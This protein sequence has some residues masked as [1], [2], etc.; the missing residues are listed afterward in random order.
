MKMKKRIGAGV[1]AIALALSLAACGEGTGNS[2]SEVMSQVG[3]QGTANMTPKAILTQSGKASEDLTDIQA[4]M[5]AEVKMTAQGETMNMDIDM[6]MIAK[7]SPVRAQM[8]M[9]INLSL[10]GEKQSQAMNMYMLE[11]NGKVSMYLGMDGK[12]QKASIDLG[13]SQEQLEKYSKQVDTSV[14]TQDM[15]EEN[16]KVS[17]YLGMDGKWQKASI[18][19]G[20]SQEQLEKYSKQ[21]DTSVYT[22]DAEIFENK[23]VK[24]VNGKEVVVLEGELTG[25]DMIAA[26]KDSGIE[27][28]LAQLGQAGMSLEDF[29]TQSGMKIV[30]YYD[31]ETLLPV[32]MTVDMTDYFKEVMEKILT[33]QNTPVPSDFKVDKYTMTITYTAFGNKVPEI[34]LPAA[35]QNATTMTL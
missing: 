19:L 3:A 18:D 4:N 23:G 6:D 2:A 12:W 29:K 15:L 28:Q 31:A 10:G 30:G 24:K 5:K 21:V 26:L 14:Y 13:T 7:E 32:E 25:D 35:A 33:A 27:D 16:G 1:A 9:D 22:Q 8:N 34:N 11:E 17:M 20:T